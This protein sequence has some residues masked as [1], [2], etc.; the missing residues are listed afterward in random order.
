MERGHLP[1][2]SIFTLPAVRLFLVFMVLVLIRARLYLPALLLGGLVVFVESAALLSRV[3]IRRLRVKAVVD[4]CRLFPGEA[5]AIRIELHNGKRFPAFV[6]WSQLLPAEGIA[7]L[8]AEGTG[9]GPDAVEPERE[10]AS[11]VRLAPHEAKIVRLPFRAVRR[12]VFPLAPL[13]VW[14]ADPFGLFRRRIAVAHPEPLV[15]FPAPAAVEGLPPSAS[16]LAGPVRSPRPFFFDPVRSIGLKEYD[17]AL[18]ARH[19]HWKASARRGRLLARVLESS[20]DRKLL[21]TIDMDAFQGEGAA[22]DFESALSQAAALVLEADA[23]RVPFGFASNAAQT[24]RDGAICLPVARS[25]GQAGAVLEA[26][27]RAGCRPAGT[28]SAL[29]A[30]EA[31]HIPWGTTVLSIGPD[32]IEE[33]AP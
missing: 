6:S 19:I 11:T 16:D 24:S 12:G 13:Q 18:P 30:G 9:S 17:P 14:T 29:L 4:P 26:L 32:R 10:Q 23:A 1:A 22:A 7:P 25:A 3:G 31:V 8:P 21:F 28:L 27:A 15:V 2:V 20:S 33:V 5:G